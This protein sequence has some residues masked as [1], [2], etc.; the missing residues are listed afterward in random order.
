MDFDCLVS[1]SSYGLCTHVGLYDEN[2]ASTVPHFFSTGLFMSFEG[3]YC[4]VRIK[5]SQ[6]INCPLGYSW[7]F[8]LHLGNICCY[9]QQLEFAVFHGQIS[10]IVK[11]YINL[12]CH[13]FLN[14]LQNHKIFKNSELHHKCLDSTVGFRKDDRCLA[15][16]V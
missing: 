16:S 6:V 9:G 15:I 13:F 11:I 2:T 1:Q 7:K 10:S 14:Q 4:D 8:A 12:K 3:M 5:V